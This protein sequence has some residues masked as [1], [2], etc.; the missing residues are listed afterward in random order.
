MSNRPLNHLAAAGRD[1]PLAWQQID[2]FRTGK[3]RDLPD[4]PNWCFLPMA[5]W[6]AIVSGGGNM[7]LERAIDVGRLAAL[8]TWRYSQGI[9][10]FDTS[11]YDA[12]RETVPSGDMP[13]DV[14]Y[15]LPEWSLYIE[16]PGGTWFDDALLGFWVH[17]EHDIGTK[18]PELRLLLDTEKMLIPLPLHMG[19]WTVTEAVDRALGEAAMQASIVG[20]ST[21]TADPALLSQQLFG[22]ISLVL[23]ICSDE[24]EIDDSKEPGISPKR[25]TPTRTKGGWRLFPAKRPHVWNVGLKLGEQLRKPA[26]EKLTD[27]ARTVSPHLRRAHWH[28]YW[29]GPRDGERRFHYKWLP[30]TAVNAKQ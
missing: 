9:Y 16:T 14:L 11:V 29:S 23:Y 3:G 18:R 5:A 28:G 24:P 8:G 2:T 22:L 7:P 21:P 1:Y 26:Q 12:L 4:W 13:V 30:P 15:R 20:I 6:F 17:L 10:R 25:P 27:D 19:K